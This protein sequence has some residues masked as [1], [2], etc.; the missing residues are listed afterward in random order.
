MNSVTE[1]VSNLEFQ[2]ATARKRITELENGICEIVNA[3]EGGDLAGA[4]NEA[5]GLLPDDAQPEPTNGERIAAAVADY[6]A[7]VATPGQAQDIAEADLIYAVR[8]IVEGS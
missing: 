3:W 5:A 8:C 2:L 7:T 6:E 1:A 4:V